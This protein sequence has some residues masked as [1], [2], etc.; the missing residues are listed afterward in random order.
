MM[1]IKYIEQIIGKCFFFQNAVLDI[2]DLDVSLIVLIHYTEKIARTYAIVLLLSTA[3]SCLDVL[4]V[5][6][7]NKT[8]HVTYIYIKH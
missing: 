5:S 7:Y 6:T 3:I 1:K 4:R 2:A 8:I